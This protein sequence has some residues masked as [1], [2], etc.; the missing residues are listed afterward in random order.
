MCLEHEGFGSGRLNAEM[1][2]EDA[3]SSH[4]YRLPK[5]KTTASEKILN[6]VTADIFVSAL[7]VAD[8]HAYMCILDLFVLNAPTLA[9][10]I[11]ILRGQQLL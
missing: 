10:C 2:W 4:P 6:F 9:L 3:M 11:S 5:K 8:V 7:F 1:A